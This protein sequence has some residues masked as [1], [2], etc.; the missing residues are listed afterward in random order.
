M[1]LVEADDDSLFQPKQ[2]VAPRQA[3]P[4]AP[5]KRKVQRVDS[6]AGVSAVPAKP[7][8]VALGSD[9]DVLNGS[10]AGVVSA[11]AED[12]EKTGVAEDTVDEEPEGAKA[13]IPVASQS[14][15]PRTVAI[16]IA[17]VPRI[18]LA[19][20]I[21]PGPPSAAQRAAA[22]A[23]RVPD[24]EPPPRDKPK[25]KSLRWAED[26]KLVSVRTFNKD[27]PAIEAR[28]DVPGNGSLLSSMSREHTP[29]DAYH[30]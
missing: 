24:W 11:Q 29:G 1:A 17:N 30:A 19:P 23:A 20:I 21:N 6:V 9:A 4:Y 16:K 22:A 7:E 5:P 26:E 8:E 12:K 15:K 18:S 2:K 3:R 14:E 28:A 27:A 10:E 25:A 13:A